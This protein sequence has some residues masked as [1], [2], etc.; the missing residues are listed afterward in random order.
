MNDYIRD[1]IGILIIILT[2]V[3]Y[4]TVAAQEIAVKTNLFY[5]G[6]IQTPNIGVEWK[7]SP[8]LTLDL[9]GAYNPFPLGKSGLGLGNRKMKH[10]LVQPE[11][12]YWFCES[13]N[14]HFWGGHIFYGEYNIG[15][16][17]YL[18]LGDYRRQGNLVGVG[19]SYGYQWILSPHWSI[20]GVIGVGYA[21]LHYNKYPCK[22]CGKRISIENR[23]YWGPTRAAISVI[24]VLK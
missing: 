16:I 23:N 10:W 11:F 14:G 9:W 17:H 22:E 21:R 24:Y 7:I 2:L 15:N 6:L 19:I 20:E 13:F 18:G 4:F 5:G 1:K 12:R 3:G 8:K